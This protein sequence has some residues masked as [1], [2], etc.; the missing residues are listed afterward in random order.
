MLALGTVS[1]SSRNLLD[2]LLEEN[3]RLRLD[4]ER[5]A[6]ILENQG[7]RSATLVVDSRQARRLS[8]EGVRA[9]KVVNP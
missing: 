5:L 4:F 6:F 7:R 2:D 8:D 1:I 3:H 9:A